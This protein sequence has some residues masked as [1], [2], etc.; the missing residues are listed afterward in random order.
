MKMYVVGFDLKPQYRVLLKAAKPFPEENSCDAFYSSLPHW[1]EPTRESAELRVAELHRM[2][3]HKNDHYCNL[4]VEQISDS[5]F[6]MVCNDH[7]RVD[8]FRFPGSM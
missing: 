8:S 3:I 7:P 2:K 6:A 1:T 5:E 4:E